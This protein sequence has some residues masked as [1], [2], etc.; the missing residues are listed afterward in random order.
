MD[1][2][3]K[4]ITV[5]HDQWLSTIPTLCLVNLTV[6]ETK[7]K[8]VDT[9]T[10]SW[11]E[12][13]LYAHKL[14]NDGEF[15]EILL[16]EEEKFDVTNDG[17]DIRNQSNTIFELRRK[18]PC[19]NKQGVLCDAWKTINDFLPEELYDVW[20]TIN[21]FLQ[22][23]KKEKEEALRDESLKTEGE[24][25]WLKRIVNNLFAEYDDSDEEDRD[26]ID[27]FQHLTWLSDEERTLRKMERHTGIPMETLEEISK[28]ETPK[29]I[30]YIGEVNEWDI[31]DLY[32]R[33]KPVLFCVKKIQHPETNWEK[34]KITLTKITPRNDS[35]DKIMKFT[36][37]GTTS[38]L[39]EFRFTKSR[40]NA[41]DLSK[42]VMHIEE[43]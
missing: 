11:V 32:M 41:R 29:E 15:I 37:K 26:T 5:V 38:S 31:I 28:R 19:I 18:V 35:E 36:P 17:F 23:K 4:W 6:W 24:V 39:G 22:E 8:L 20:K 21:D 7:K 43:E 12:Y 13:D 25:R 30:Q 10:S 14:G 9:I 34:V 3:K 33:W 16:A 2:I 42:E 40:I 27:K 1:D